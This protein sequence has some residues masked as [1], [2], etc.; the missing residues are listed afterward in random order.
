MEPLSRRSLLRAGGTLGAAGALAIAGQAVP[1]TWAPAWSRPGEGSG[2][3]PRTVYDPEAD[4]LIASLLD[5]RE[6]PRVNQILRGWTTNAQPVPDDLPA[7]LRDFVQRAVQLPEWTDHTKLADA[8][9]FNE[10]RGTYL[11]VLYGF[12]SEM[13]STVIPGRRGRSTTP[14]AAP[15]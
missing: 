2:V 13:M 6:I 15:T 12:A 11:G 7:D 8:V 4:E 5:R 14:R 9:R 3:D 1:W 10:K